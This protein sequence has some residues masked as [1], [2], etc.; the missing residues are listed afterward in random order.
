MRICVLWDA[1][2]AVLRGNLLKWS[3]KKKK[4]KQKVLTDLSNT[5]KTLEQKHIELHK[6]QILEEIKVM[7]QQINKILD[8]QVEIKLKYIKQNYYENGP[9]AKKCYHG[10]S[11]NSKL[12]GQ[13][14]KLEIQKP[15]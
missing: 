4:E 13:F 7:K 8:N 12:K 9:R 14:I 10:N 3:S 2:K 6:P 11:V 5:L 1:A 15:M